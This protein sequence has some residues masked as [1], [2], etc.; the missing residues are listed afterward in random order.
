[1]SANEELQ[2]ARALIQAKRYAEA[3]QV[4]KNIDHPT[5]K[6]WLARLDEVAPEKPAP[7]KQST[8]AGAPARKAQPAPTRK[9]APAPKPQRGGGCLRSVLLLA[10]I[11]VVGGLAVFAVPYL[12]NQRILNEL[13]LTLTPLPAFNVIVEATASP[14]PNIVATANA[15]PPTV[16]GINATGLPTMPPL[17]SPELTA[18][19]VLAVS[20]EAE[21]QI[22]PENQLVVNHDAV[23]Q[24]VINAPLGWQNDGISLYRD[25]LEN[26]EV[27]LARLSGTTRLIPLEQII[28]GR[29]DSTSVVTITETSAN[30]RQVFMIEELEAEDQTS[31]SYYVKDSDGDVLV[32]IVQA[33]VEDK[34]SLHDDLLTMVSGVE[35]E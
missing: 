30:G 15:V 7:Q 19:S 34:A 10:L 2:R 14:A 3:R 11:I 26:F 27:T 9:P 28:N 18:T 21:T 13:A 33:T 32:F 22:T 5:A 6:K 16:A 4:L 1:M 31:L 17:P 35:A 25:T 12:N 8:P 24:V 23:G 20:L 29:R